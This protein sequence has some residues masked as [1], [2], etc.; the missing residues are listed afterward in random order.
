MELD[1]KLAILKW[2]LTQRQYA[3]DTA[4]VILLEEKIEELEERKITDMMCNAMRRKNK[5][6]ID[7][8]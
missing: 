8:G 2:E 4:I 6:L 7:D 1:K 3:E 5:E